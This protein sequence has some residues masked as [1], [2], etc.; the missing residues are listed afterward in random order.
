M[1]KFLLSHR[2]GLWA[3]QHTSWAQHRDLTVA[4]SILCCLPKELLAYNSVWY[5]RLQFLKSVFPIIWLFHLWPLSSYSLIFSPYLNSHADHD[6][7]EEMVIVKTEKIEEGC[8][9]D[10]GNCEG[11]VSGVLKIMCGN[12]WQ[13][14]GGDI[15]GPWLVLWYVRNTLLFFASWEKMR[16]SFSISHENVLRN[17]GIFVTWTES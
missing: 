9:N 8:S 17:P 13:S 3:T 2:N 5:W 14:F 10:G 1:G 11:Q 12:S 16:W 7:S 4:L 15:V 6:I